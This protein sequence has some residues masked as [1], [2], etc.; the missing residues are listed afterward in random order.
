MDAGLAGVLGAVA[1]ALAT[2]G[3]ALATGRA[4]REQARIAARAEHVRQRREPR[5]GIYHDFL[6]VTSE[7]RDVVLGRCFDTAR[8]LTH[9]GQDV[10]S[11]LASSTAVVREHGLHV[12]LVGPEEV[13]A[14][15]SEV[16]GACRE[17]ARAAHWVAVFDS[18]P[19]GEGIP[20]DDYNDVHRR[21]L[22]TAQELAGAVETF[23][24]AAQSA[25]DADGT[26]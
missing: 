25:L 13:G 20:S 23:I 14:A 12:M 1:G 21:A 5:R 9:Q 11:W 8:G 10:R 3:A 15:A 7:V 2:T 18:S 19:E 16:A 17:A 6:A 24:K 4:S 22:D 26:C